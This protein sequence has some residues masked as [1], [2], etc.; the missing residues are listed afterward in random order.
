MSS[1][2]PPPAPTGLPELPE[3]L[4]STI[5]TLNLD[6]HVYHEMTG[7]SFVVINSRR[8]QAGDTLSEGPLL[9]SITADGVVLT[10]Q[11]QRFLLPV[12]R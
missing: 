9:E 7:R 12:H 4:Q 11:G 6:I 3:A 1:P 5:P 2:V 8:Y 10:Q